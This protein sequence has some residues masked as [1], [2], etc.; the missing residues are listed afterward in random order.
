MDSLT[1]VVL[2]GA[3]GYAVLGNKVGRKAAIYGAILGTLPDL[4]VFLPYG[5][6][7]EAFTYHRGFSHSILV[8]LLISPFI[9]W[10]ITTWHKSTEV[11]K[12]RWF[13]LVFLCLTTHA[14]LD[15]FTVYGTQLLWPIT[16]HPFAASNLFII[17]PI[18]TLPLLV[19]FIVV[20]LPSFKPINASKINSSA[21]LISSLYV[22]WSLAAKA[23]ID[24]KVEIALND[25]QVKVNHYLSSPA[26][27]S[28]LLWRILVMSDGQYYEGYVSVFDSSS[29]VSLDA[30]SSSDSLLANVKDEWGVQRLQWFTKGFYSVKQEQQNIVL[31][32]LRMGVEC[33]YVFNFIVGEQTN[34]EIVTGNFEKYSNRPD[35]SQ[36]GSIW[37]RIWD[38]SVSLAPDK[39]NGVCVSSKD[40]M[41]SDHNT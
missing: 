28:T 7:V 12:T 3:V 16:E 24:Q 32:D 8:H 36:L 21:L 33:G 30:H 40:D 38:P 6:E 2:G 39:N 4:D 15:S 41:L 18:Y 23:Y 5:G 10:L 11:Y 37:D 35:L 20:L 27:L 19:A 17:D 34:T 14:I 25:R 13:W 29:E 26:P 1:Q 22:C 31:S 9:V